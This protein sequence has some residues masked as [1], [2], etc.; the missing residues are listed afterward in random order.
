MEFINELG[1]TIKI[2]S[3]KKEIENVEGIFFSIEGPTST[4]EVHIT[5]E[6][7][8]VLKNKLDEILK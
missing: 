8:R 2:E 6:E 4:T 5:K 7:A 1:N 3:I